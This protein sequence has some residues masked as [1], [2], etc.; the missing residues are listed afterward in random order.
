MYPFSPMHHVRRPKS[1]EIQS[2]EHTLIADG[3]VGSEDSLLAI[4]ALVLGQE[5][6][7]NGQTRNVVGLGELE[8][9]SLGVVVDQLDLGE[10]QGQET[11]FTTSESLL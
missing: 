7:S 6:A 4:R 1:S 5:R 11:L 2:S 10:L 9:E 3:S 8:A